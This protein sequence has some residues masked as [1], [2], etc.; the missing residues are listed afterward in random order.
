LLERLKS[1]TQFDRVYNANLSSGPGNWRWFFTTTAST[2]ACVFWN[3]CMFEFEFILRPTVSR[4]FRLGI[5]PL[6]GTLD[7]ILSCSS[8]FVWQLL[9]SSF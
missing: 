6:F 9:Y 5:G 7:R 4:P 2:Y 3:I 1:G 8:F